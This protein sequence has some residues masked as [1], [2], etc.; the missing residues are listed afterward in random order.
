M[1]K[2]KI[3]KS[4]VKKAKEIIQAGGVII[5]PT[6]TVY[7]IGTS[8]KSKKGIKRIFEIKNRPKDKQLQ[9][10][11]SDLKQLKDLAVSIPAYAKDLM[12][13]Y[14]PGPLTLVLKKKGGGTIGVRMPYHVELLKI[15]QDCGPM[16]A[17][18]ANVSGCPAP[19]SASEV[20]I[21]ADLLLDGGKCKFKLA[22]TV[23]DATSK[24]PTVLRHGKIK[25]K[26]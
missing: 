8:I 17:T 7:G 18:S 23:I 12:A 20:K 10:L 25:I 6:E 15:L 4:S 9:V 13:E 26:N 21:E 1:Q 16:F 2:L 5:F 11:I 24:P 14:W 3:N 22:S 19:T